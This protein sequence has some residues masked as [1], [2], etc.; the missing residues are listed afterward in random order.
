[1]SYRTLSAVAL[2]LALA[3]CSSDA[4]APTGSTC[5]PTST[6]TYDNF[7]KKFMEDYCTR[8]HAS[9][10]FGDDRMGAPLYHDF[11]TLIGILHV[12]DH[13]DE[14]AAAGPDA[15]NRFMPAEAPKPTDAERYELGEWIACERQR[16]DSG[17]DAGVDAPAAD[18][19]PDAPAL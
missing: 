3:A 11:D 8:C 5:P 17:A 4:P 9:Y 7:G 14:Y 12:A 18:G 16:L 15:I 6:L 19:A 1:M 13:V 2:C 10:L